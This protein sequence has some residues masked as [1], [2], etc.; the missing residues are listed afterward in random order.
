MEKFETRESHIIE[1]DGVKIFSVLHRPLQVKNPPVVVVFHGFGGHKVGHARVYVNEAELLSKAGIATLRFDF[2]G[3]GDSEGR[4][5]EMTIGSEVSDALSVLDYLHT[6]GSV[7]MSRLGFLG[8]SLGGLIAVLT[9]KESLKKKKI[10]P[11]SLALWAPAFHAEQWAKLWDVIQDPKT[12][13]KMRAELMSFN[14]IQVYPKF[15]EEFISLNLEE[16]MHSLHETPLLHIHGL[17]DIGIDLSHARRY[18]EI[19][20]LASAETSLIR[21]P[22][23]DHEFEQ[24]EEQ[25]LTLQETCQWFVN[26]L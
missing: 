15:V 18:E 7:D 10:A 25:A 14:G 13:D 8:K 22:N 11:K 12:T 5:S 17:Q 4:W 24:P 2:Q 20:K 3:C 6:L 26:T 16:A 9:A 19:R 23:T 21:L 1:K